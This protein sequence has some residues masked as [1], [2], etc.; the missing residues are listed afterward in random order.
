[1]R[2]FKNLVIAIAS[3][4]FLTVGLYSCSNDEVNNS[5]QQ[6]VQNENFQSKPVRTSDEGYLYAQGFYSSDISLGRSIDLVDPDTNEGVT[7]TEVTVSGDSRARGYIVNKVENYDFLYFVDVDRTNNVLK[8]YEAATAQ[9]T[10]FNNIEESPEYL[11][12]DKFD[13]ITYSP[14]AMNTTYGTGCSCGFWKRM[15]GSCSEY[16]TEVYPGGGIDGGPGCQKFKNEKSHFLGLTFGDGWLPT[17]GI[18]PC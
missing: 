15:F 17:T 5:E 6:N 16:K 3:A 2:R 10:V 7:V 14:D 9:T 8:G 13:F 11:A 12:T 18:N 4:T 1:M